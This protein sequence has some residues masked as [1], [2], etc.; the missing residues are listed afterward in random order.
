MNKM[1]KKNTLSM[2]VLATLSG[3][4]GP[5]FAQAD[6]PEI[7][8]EVIVTGIRSAL[9]NALEEKRDSSNIKEVIQAEDIGKLPDQNLAEVLENITGIQ[10]NRT[11]GVGT[12]VQ[13][14]GT[15]SN[16]VEINGVSTVGAANG[17]SGINF[18]DLPAALIGSVEVTKVPEAKTVE[19]SVGGTINLR[20]LRGLELK[21]RVTSLRVQAENSDLADSTTPRISGTFGDNWET[22][23]GDIG[24]VVSASYVQQDV[25]SFSPRFD[26]DGVVLPDSG[27]GSAESFPFLRTQFLDQM[28]SRTEYETKN[29][30]SSIEWAPNDDLKLYMDLTFNDQERVGQDNR[31]LFSGTGSNAAVDNTINTQFETINLGRID[32]PNGPLELGA[33][34]AVLTGVIGVG[35]LPNGSIESNLRTQ[36]IAGS[37]LT[38]STV[39]AFGGE[40]D[41]DKLKLSAEFSHSESDTTFPRIAATT[42]FINPRGPQPS[43]AFPKVE[44]TDT[45][46]EIPA[47]PGSIDN[48]VPAIFD[49]RN[50]TLQF[51]IAPNYVDP[52]SG[53]LLTPTR[54]E[55]LDPANYAFRQLQQSR[56]TN[57]NSETALRLDANY[58][59]SEDNPFFVSIHGGFR[60][61]ENSAENNDIART[62]N[63]ANAN[64]RFFRPKG[65]LFADILVP[66]Q[67]NFDAA[68][69]R[70]LF[71]RD[72]LLVSPEL[73]FRNPGAIV[74]SLN[75]AI[76]QSNMDS[77]VN[78]PLIGDPSIS[79]TGF[80]EIDEETIALYVQGDYEFDIGNVPVRGN[81]G[82]RWVSTDITSSGNNQEQEVDENGDLVFN[83]NGSPVLAFTP[84]SSD[85]SYSVLLPRINLVA[86]L[87]E[88]V[89]VRAGIASDIRR[90]NF[91]DLSTSFSFGSNASTPIVFGNSQLEPEEVLSFD[92]STEYY[93]S[94][95]G[96]VSVGFFH[97]ERENLIAS[98]RDDPIAPIGSDGQ[99][100][101]EITPS[102]DPQIA[103]FC[104]GGGIFNPVADRNVFSSIQGTG[105]CVPTSS[106]FNVSGDTTQS[107]IELAFQ[108]DLSDFE[109]T[110]GWASGFGFI[111]NY[112]YQKS[113]GSS[114]E[115]RVATADNNALN[116][117][118]GRPDGAVVGGEQGFDTQTLAD[119]IAAEEIVL[120]NL[121]QN[122]YNATLFYDKYGLNVRMR[123]TWRSSFKTNSLVSFGLPRIVDDRAQLNMSA[124]YDINDTF[125]VGI[126]GIN[127]LREDRSQWC[128]NEGALLCAQGL[129][130]RR[131]TVGVTANF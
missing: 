14:R 13:I 40:W 77:N 89:L 19:G 12:G 124:T 55:L 96:F 35:V 25:V 34:T 123:Y 47:V 10:I 129:T 115:F 53:E 61:N 98:E 125:T 16:R 71:V 41:R 17:R 119:D 5:V 62:T 109:D 76:T 50:R 106:R 49:A 78:Y 130:D 42:D 15:G 46:P 117:L 103:P 128:V 108:Y 66:G 6:G 97:K 60:W 1:L 48:G 51:G 93:F 102:S 120:T 11:Q 111:G 86:E 39:F 87:R 7:T 30:T 92:L 28:L 57:E 37:R 44:E 20:T 52:I 67:D 110:L 68:D 21:D 99:E 3:I 26:R 74:T 56:D 36:T 59:I 18:D 38:E 121:S 27:R 95:A 70:N 73:A 22:D 105:I 75:N 69:G 94:D 33:A 101:R 100:N 131:F 8:E 24:V 23:I 104:D 4:T 32:G 29:I 54:E 113:G 82:L 90:P 43:Q 127:L 64:S 112:T 118:L 83:E 31:A 63:F 126:E 2:A 80:F 116:L 122:A 114:N 85:S 45:T 84:S 58:D 65:N 107:G 9:Q 81:V 91:N 79:Q 88:D 72:Y